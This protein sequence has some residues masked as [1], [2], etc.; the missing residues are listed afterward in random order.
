MYGRNGLDFRLD[1]NSV[2]DERNDMLLVDRNG[3][4]ERS[5]ADQKESDA[6]CKESNV[7]QSGRD[8]VGIESDVRCRVRD[9]YDMERIA[10]RSRRDVNGTENVMS[11]VA[12][13]IFLLATLT[14][15]VRSTLSTRNEIGLHS[16]KSPGAE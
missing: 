7:D 9:V 10:D 5:G 6:D 16:C 2:R 13:S 12:H 3:I 4:V 15:D 11:D 1:G 14:E 8:V